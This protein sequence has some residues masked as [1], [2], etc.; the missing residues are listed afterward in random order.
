[1]TVFVKI[2]G[3]TTPDAAHA[4]AE[5]GADAVGFV[6]AESPRRLTPGRASE[7]AAE[8]PEDIEKVAVFRRPS[9]DEVRFVLDRFDAD[10]VQAD[11]PN[12][13]GLTGHKTLPVVRQA[14]PGLV[15]Q[16][17][18]FDSVHSG[19]GTRSDWASAS[20]LSQTS[21]LILAGGLNPNNVGQAIREVTPYGVDVSSGVE[22]REG[23]KDPVLVREFVVEARRVE[24]EMVST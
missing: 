13:D 11:R 18:L 7:L 20:I 23:V 15:G 24:Q 8:L 14:E 17:I 2:C 19:T 10:T 4:A 6:F 1:M 21:L 5:S 9:L 3:I 12:L 22:S 16:R